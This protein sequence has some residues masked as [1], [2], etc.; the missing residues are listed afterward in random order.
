MRLWRGRGGPR[1]GTIVRFDE[2]VLPMHIPKW[3]IATAGLLFVVLIA[4]VAFFIGRETS[5]RPAAIAAAAALQEPSPVREPSSVQG[6]TPVR[7]SGPE[8]PN[9]PPAE[10]SALTPIITPSV[11]M[12][13]SSNAATWSASVP[14]PAADSSQATAEARA[15]VAAYFKQMEAI[16]SGGTIGDQQEFGTSVVNAAASGDFS[17]IDDLVRAA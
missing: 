7:D 1:R 6:P 11:S 5:R 15:R 13:A 2:S 10:A 16:G 14:T 9:L 4:G 17:G 12:R 3:L 8:E